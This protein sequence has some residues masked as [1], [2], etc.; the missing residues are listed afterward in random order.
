MRS[1]TPTGRK[2]D[3]TRT[4][5]PRSAIQLHTLRALDE[6]LPET[7]R[8]VADAGFDGV[9]FAGRFLESN[10]EAVRSAL[11]T[12][13]T[14]PV[15]AHADLARIEGNVEQIADRCRR[16]GCQRVIVPHLSAS[17]FRTVGRV[18]SL[19]RRLDDLAERV[20]NRGLELS[21]HTSRHPFLPLLNGYGLRL[22]AAAPIPFGFWQ[23]VA[24][25]I[26]V[27]DRRERQSLG[28]TGLA[29]LVSQTTDITFELDIGWAAAA[30]YDAGD[31]LE[32]LGDR[33]SLVHIADVDRTRRFPP[34]FR[35]VPYGEGVV[36]VER[37]LAAVGNADIEW[38]VYEDDEPA[39]P[40]EA[41]Q[42][43]KAALAPFLG[44]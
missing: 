29:R 17:H 2:D 5:D 13:D 35:S 7:I 33:C 16:V 6:S 3:P 34:A 22:P 27:T 25:G 44:G 43:G 15:A 20:R 26:D 41:V 30:R 19:A 31:V 32:L 24:D 42:Q 12:T 4:G 14:V 11:E 1:V 10:P 36:D 21:Y 18:D 39:D 38:V 37:V 8:R 40:A 28:R 23:T 9:E